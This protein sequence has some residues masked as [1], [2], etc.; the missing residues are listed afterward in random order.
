MCQSL[1][2]VADYTA[3]C[4]DFRQCLNHSDSLAVLQPVQILTMFQSFWLVD[5]CVAVSIDFEHCFS[6]FDWLMAA[7]YV[8]MFQPFLICWWL[9]FMQQI[10]DFK[11][12]FNHSDWLM[13]VLQLAQI[14]STWYP[15]MVHR[16]LV[17][18]RI[19]WWLVL[20]LP[21]EDNSFSGESTLLQID[22]SLSG[23]PFFWWNIFGLNVMIMRLVNSHLIS[24]NFEQLVLCMD[25]VV[26]I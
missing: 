14:S 18:F 3:A 7:L 13:A 24:S 23:W 22:I 21:Y 12:C 16:W 9:Y 26:H 8:E 20:L 17:S 19:T 10:T 5:G 6:H 2:L 15:R 25:K 1:W 4:T 11:P